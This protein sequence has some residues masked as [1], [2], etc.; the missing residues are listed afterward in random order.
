MKSSFTP[1]RK[2]P[3]LSFN[4]LDRTAQ[5]AQ[6]FLHHVAGFGRRRYGGCRG[7]RSHFRSSLLLS[8]QRNDGNSDLGREKPARKILQGRKVF[9]I[10]QITQIMPVFHADPE[11]TRRKLEG[12]NPFQVGS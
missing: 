6:R 11:L 12:G 1:A 5:Y 7:L 9:G 10:L 4:L 3:V 8:R 2:L